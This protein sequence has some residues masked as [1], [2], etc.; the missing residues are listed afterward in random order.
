[1]PAR[2][3]VVPKTQDGQED[4]GKVGEGGGNKIKVGTKVLDRFAGVI[5]PVL[6]DTNIY[7]YIHAVGH[8]CWKV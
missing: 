6:G 4:G 3:Q 8:I 7:T 5:N 2:H 1:M